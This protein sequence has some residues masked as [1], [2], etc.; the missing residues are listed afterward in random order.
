MIDKH[1]NYIYTRPDVTYHMYIDMCGHGCGRRRATQYKREIKRSSSPNP[2]PNT[3]GAQSRQP[4]TLKANRS[5]QRAAAAASP[6]RPQS[7]P[8]AS[9]PQRGRSGQLGA[10]PTPSPQPKPCPTLQQAT[11]PSSPPFPTP[12]CMLG[13]QG[14]DARGRAVRG[15]WRGCWRELVVCGCGCGCG[16][17]G[18]G[19]CGHTRTNG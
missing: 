15:P 11:L 1:I 17:M 16:H 5:A 12:S 7:T 18:L 13:R 10:A 8:I 2:G 3:A 19:M 6:R 14:R 4:C 9:A